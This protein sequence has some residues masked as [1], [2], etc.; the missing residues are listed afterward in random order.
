[1][2]AVYD[3]HLR[4]RLALLQDTMTSPMPP[5]TIYTP[6]MVE[7]FLRYKDLLTRLFPIKGEVLDPGYDEDTLSLLEEAFIACDSTD[8]AKLSSVVAEAKAR[9]M[10]ERRGQLESIETIETDARIK[11]EE[12]MAKWEELPSRTRIRRSGTTYLDRFRK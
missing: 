1:M 11:I 12:M 7:S 5:N 4:S 3:D 10:N 9:Y 6:P 8:T 2:D